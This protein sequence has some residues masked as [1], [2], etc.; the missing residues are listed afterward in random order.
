MW[1]AFPHRWNFEGANHHQRITNPD[2]AWQS[3]IPSFSIIYIYIFKKRKACVQREKGA[4]IQ[5]GVLWQDYVDGGVALCTHVER[6][7]AHVGRHFWPNRRFWVCFFFGRFFYALYRRTTKSRNDGFAS[8]IN[9]DCNI[10]G[11]VRS[12]HKLVKSVPAIFV[13]LCS[14]FFCTFQVFKNQRL[15]Y[16][17]SD[18]CGHLLALHHSTKSQ[19]NRLVCMLCSRISDEG[20]KVCKCE[21]K[22]G[23]GK[24]KE[25]EEKKEM[26]NAN[27][28]RR[29]S[30]VHR[31]CGVHRWYPQ[32]H[33][34]TVFSLC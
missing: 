19:K 33:L 1:S 24:K 15:V 18:I 4:E 13:W 26:S 2:H 11:P 8:F 34:W 25:K 6:I 31:W 7:I 23:S 3:W 14:T 21:E 12:Y 9:V 22:K 16:S 27:L 5:M 32:H 30:P 28:V 20:A 17:N 29:Q 10:H